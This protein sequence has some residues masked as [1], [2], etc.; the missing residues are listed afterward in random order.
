MKWID[1]ADERDRAELKFL[2]EL[3]KI[4][5]LRE[6]REREEDSRSARLR[7]IKHGHIFNPATLSCAKCG[8]DE[9]EYALT[10]DPGHP[11]ENEYQCVEGMN[12][13]A[14]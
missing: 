2:F 5:R 14:S 11:L 12:E 4:E 1:E 3:P 6:Q 13:H 9:I 10:Q 7:A 8:M